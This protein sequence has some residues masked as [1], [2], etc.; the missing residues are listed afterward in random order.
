MSMFTIH[1]V[2]GSPFGRSAMAALVEKG[3]DWRLAALAPGE[4]KSAA[5]LVRQPFGRVPLLE[6]GDFELYETQAI[7]RYIDRVLPDPA[8]TPADRQAAAR[9]DQLMGINDWYL[10]QGCVNV[11]GFHRIIAPKFTGA[12]P[13]LDAIALAMP[14]AHLVLETISWFLGDQPFLVGDGLTLADL[15]IGPQ[16]GFLTYTPE[17]A[18][19][20][21]DRPNLAAWLDRLESRPSFQ[22][23]T[24]EKLTELAQAA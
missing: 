7:L 13:D 4:T 1:S 21:K 22:Q 19:L 5:Y 18:E 14:R 11:I 15:M 24:W 2:P 9:M 20:S 10:F 17:W 12:A 23:T 6:H 16:V 3:A 8:L